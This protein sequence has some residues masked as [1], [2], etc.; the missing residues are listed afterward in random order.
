MVDERFCASTM[1]SL[2]QSPSFAGSQAPTPPPQ[3]AAPT[4]CEGRQDLGSLFWYRSSDECATWDE[5]LDNGDPAV[6]NLE[7]VE[8]I[9]RG[10]ETVRAFF[11]QTFEFHGLLW[12]CVYGIQGG[13]H[14]AHRSTGDEVDYGMGFEFEADC[15]EDGYAEVR[16]YTGHEESE[17]VFG[18]HT[19][20]IPDTCDIG[21]D[22]AT[23]DQGRCYYKVRLAC[24]C[25]ADTS[26]EGCVEG[27]QEVAVGN[28]ND[29]TSAVE[30]YNPDTGGSCPHGV[31]CSMSDTDYRFS[32]NNLVEGA[33]EY[34]CEVYEGQD[35]PVQLSFKVHKATDDFA[36]LKLLTEGWTMSSFLI[37]SDTGDLAEYTWSEGG[38]AVGKFESVG[39]G[40][41]E[42]T[43]VCVENRPCGGFA[44]T[45][46][47]TDMPTVAECYV[48]SYNRRRSNKKGDAKDFAL[49]QSTCPVNTYHCSIGSIGDLNENKTVPC[50]VGGEE[51]N[52]TYIVLDSTADGDMAK[53]AL[54]VSDLEYVLVNVFSSQPTNETAG[55]LYHWGSDPAKPDQFIFQGSYKSGLVRGPDK[56]AAVDAVDI[57]ISQTCCVE[58][59]NEY[60]TKE[61]DPALRY[62]PDFTD[63]HD[64]C[65]YNGWFCNLATGAENVISQTD[66][67]CVS[68]W[69]Y[70]VNVDMAVSK[71]SDGAATEI[72]IEARDCHLLTAVYTENSGDEKG[73]SYEFGSDTFKP[74]GERGSDPKVSFG[75][76][77]VEHHV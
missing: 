24:A 32:Y 15:D 64:N 60:D 61:R 63:G 53:Y 77:T 39:G 14:A 75:F 42:H 51:V 27:D 12:W 45:P 10:S 71:G 2:S 38:A 33:A 58:D 50:D 37:K 40:I 28:T 26:L 70:T 17:A 35:S 16:I 8:V 23:D 19:V 22:E 48:N 65:P 66:I 43:E 62:D 73:L 59:T 1:P 46:E 76:I 68:P 41:I 44:P 11:R 67:P 5:A 52:V 18:W 4:D 47:P 54:T 56:T 72:S 3:T 69:G 34:T 20:V 6:E 49:T 7:P 25:N 36:E 74:V 31:L 9:Y 57:C 55:Y 30:V 13:R 29:F 21:Q